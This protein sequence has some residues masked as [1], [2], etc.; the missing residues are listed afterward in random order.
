MTYIQKGSQT[1][2]PTI[3][4]TKLK[5]RIWDSRKNGTAFQNR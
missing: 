3:Q 4:K 1:N 2:K 5:S